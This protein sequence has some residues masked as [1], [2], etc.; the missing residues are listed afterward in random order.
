MFGMKLKKS[1][2]DNLEILEEIIILLKNNGFEEER[3]LLKNEI[4][5]SSTGGE[6][7]ARCGS[8]LLTFNKQQNIKKLIGKQ[9]SE[10]IDYCHSI[11]L[12]PIPREDK[13]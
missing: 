1:T 6:I 2:K 5:S 4:L 12:I 13:T 11:G 9:T 3:L 8:L 7:S 10:F